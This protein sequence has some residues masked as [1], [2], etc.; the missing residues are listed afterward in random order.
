MK[1]LFKTQHLQE[2]FDKN[3]LVRVPLLTAAQTDE[4]LLGYKSLEV[5]HEQIGLPFTTTSHSNDYRLIQKADEAI[6][7]VFAPEMDK[8]LCD[9]KL[10]FGNFLI[11]QTGPES[12]TPIHQDTSFVD[13][14][15]FTSI[16]VWVSLQD[17]DQRN[18]CMRF[19]NGSHRFKHILRP[20]HAYAWPFEGVKERLGELLEDYPSR[21]GEAFIFDHR[22][23]HASYPNLTENPRVAAVM[24]AYP[25]EAELLMYFLKKDST[26]IV[27][28]YKMTKE[29]YL[30]FTKGEPPVAGDLI[31]TETFDYL[32]VTSDELRAMLPS[33]SFVQQVRELLSI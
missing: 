22:L 8:Y 17:T 3:G 1:Q 24:A 29:A 20:T 32:P 10:L 28:K 19:I 26:T 2:E 16:S 11:K 13:E 21:K 14:S 27:E 30:H 23:I 33:R 15:R 5:E 4:L 31:E 9:Y 18:G 25:S 7:S 12:V 6:A